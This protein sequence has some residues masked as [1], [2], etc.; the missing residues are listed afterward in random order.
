MSDATVNTD[1]TI[2]SMV[3][4]FETVSNIISGKKSKDNIWSVN[5]EA[6]YHE[7]NSDEKGES[8]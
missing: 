8:N 7:E 6:E 2:Y 5:T 4:S 3:T 1:I